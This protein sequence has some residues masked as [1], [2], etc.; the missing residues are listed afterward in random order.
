MEELIDDDVLQI[1]RRG[2]A[3]RSLPAVRTSA[4]VTDL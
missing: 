4:D 3:L 1:E 2:H